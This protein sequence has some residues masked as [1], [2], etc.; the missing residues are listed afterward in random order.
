MIFSMLN[1]GCIIINTELATFIDFFKIHPKAFLYFLSPLFS[2]D[3]P[4]V[5]QHIRIQDCG[6]ILHRS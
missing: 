2:I 3:L 4:N 1:N 6:M 5:S